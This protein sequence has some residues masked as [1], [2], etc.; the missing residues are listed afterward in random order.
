MGQGSLVVATDESA[1]GEAAE[2]ANPAARSKPGKRKRGEAKAPATDEPGSR[3]ARD[4]ATSYLS[5]H[6]ACTHCGLSF[7]PP[8]PQL[9]SFNSPQ[10]MCPA[11][12]GLG[13][14]YSFDP[15]LLVPDDALSFKDGCFEL[16]GPWRDLGRW[17]RHI[18]QGVADTMDRKLGLAKGTMLETPWNQLD[19]ELQNLWLWGT[20]DEHI[21]FTWRSG[22]IGPQVRRAG[23]RASFPT[24]STSTAIRRARCNCGSWKNTCT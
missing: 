1:A 20:G 23:S 19:A 14:L 3:A 13:E 5:A 17:K 12:D 8:S 4:R 10:G 6:Y 9:F 15:A 16:L 18:Y 21:T 22:P 24:C 11:C 7:E 2:T